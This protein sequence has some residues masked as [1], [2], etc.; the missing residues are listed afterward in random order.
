M[1]LKSFV[2]VYHYAGVHVEVKDMRHKDGTKMTAW[3][4]AKG[5]RT[6]AY[7]LRLFYFYSYEKPE[8][9]LDFST[10]I[11]SKEMLEN[12]V[13]TSDII[14]LNIGEPLIL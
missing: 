5:R 13:K 8:C 4:W 14:L 9:G 3:F 11:M 2:L 6:A 10:F 1:G 7:N 12:A